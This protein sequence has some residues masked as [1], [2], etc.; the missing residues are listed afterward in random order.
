[1]LKK[2]LLTVVLC[3]A[4][5]FIF[6]S[7]ISSNQ[8]RRDR[9]RQAALEEF[10]RKQAE[11]ALTMNR[12]VATP[13]DRAKQA[14]RDED[15]EKAIADLSSSDHDVLNEAIQKIQGYRACKA[16][17]ELQRLLKQSSDDYIAGISAQTIA[18][19]NER[20]MFDTIVDE[21]L[22]RDA[23]L[24][25]IDAVGKIATSDPRVIEKLNKLIT[26]P[27]KD[28]YVPVFARRAK[29]QLELA[30]NKPL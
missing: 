5:L 10:E 24:P 23:T 3:F 7:V 29:G 8:A 30:Q 21:F 1:M 18:V 16:V 17:P 6:L 19:C 13:E 12:G 15:A 27:N 14:Q 9:K 22:R 11:E 2:V 20:P 4:A 28:E 25:M 26:E